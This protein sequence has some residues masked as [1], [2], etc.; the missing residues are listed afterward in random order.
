MSVRRDVIL[1]DNP[2]KYCNHTHPVTTD[3][4]AASAAP[5]V[6]SLDASV[7]AQSVVVNVRLL[8][9]VLKDGAPVSVYCPLRIMGKTQIQYNLLTIN[10]DLNANTKFRPQQ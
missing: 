7:S 2:N 5:S 6:V 9:A 10:L 1:S 3:G 8:L 4:A